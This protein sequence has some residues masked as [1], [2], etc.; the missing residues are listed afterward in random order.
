MGKK[1]LETA[2]ETDLYQAVFLRSRSYSLNIKEN[3]LRCK[4]KGVQGHN[5]YTLD[6]CKNFYKFVD[7]CKYLIFYWY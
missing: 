1:K 7:I 6:D 4:H 2:P 5:K 3:S